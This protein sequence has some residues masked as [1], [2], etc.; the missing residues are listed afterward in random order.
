MTASPW[1]PLLGGSRSWAA[2]RLQASTPTGYAE[3]VE[4]AIERLELHDGGAPL[5]WLHGGYVP[6]GEPEDRA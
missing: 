2:C 1:G 5:A 3:L 6:V 4:G